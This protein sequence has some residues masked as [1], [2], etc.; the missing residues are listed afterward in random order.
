MVVDSPIPQENK[1]GS[2]A[3]IGRDQN[4]H[5]LGMQ[6]LSAEILLAQRC[7]KHLLLQGI[8]HCNPAEFFPAET[9]CPTSPVG[10][11]FYGLLVRQ[12][13]EITC[14]VRYRRR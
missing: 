3:V 14:V 8:F 13:Q 11:F 1:R 9:V 4:T 7:D 5:C 12:F 6:H 10:H 2:D